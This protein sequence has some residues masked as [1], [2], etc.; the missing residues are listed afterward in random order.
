MCPSPFF[1]FPG[2]TPRPEFAHPPR[3]SCLQGPFCCP[4]RALGSDQSPLRARRF[5]LKPCHSQSGMLAPPHIA[6]LC[7][8]SPSKIAPDRDWLSRARRS[9]PRPH[10]TFSEPRI[11]RAP[12]RTCQGMCPSTFF[13]HPCP[14]PRPDF[15]QL[16]FVCMFWYVG[17]KMYH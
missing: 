16:A 1:R 15:A 3:A 4:P 14:T 8:H 13:R 9:P 12:L 17:D 6:G 10:N 5:C 11:R 2:L 7:S